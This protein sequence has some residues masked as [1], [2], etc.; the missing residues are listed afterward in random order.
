MKKELKRKAIIGG[1]LSL[2]ALLFACGGGGGGGDTT[3]GVTPYA[4]VSG[5]VSASSN[6]AAGVVSAAGI[7]VNGVDVAYI[8][9]MGIE[10]G[11]L[12]Y[13]ADD[14]DS[15]GNFDLNLKTGLDYAFILFDSS[16][17]PVFFVNGTTGNAISVNSSGSVTITLVDT[18]GDGTPDAAQVAQTQ[19]SVS[20][21]SN[22]DLEDDPNDPDYYPESIEG[23]DYGGSPNPD[24][25]EDGDGYFDGVENN[26]DDNY[27]DGKE[28]SNNNG[29]PDVYE[30]EDSDGLPN[31]LDD[32]DGD[33]YYDHIDED[34]SDYYRYEMKGNVSNI[35]TTN[36]TFDFTYNNTTYTVSVTPQ[37]VCEIYDAYYT[38][39]ECINRIKDNDYIELKTSDD[40]NATTNITA[41]KFELENYDDDDNYTYNTR[42]EVY[43]TVTEID[44]GTQSFQFYYNNRYYTVTVDNNTKCEYNDMYYYGADCLMYLS[45]GNYIELKTYDNIFEHT[46]ITAVEIEKKK[47]EIY[48][49][50]SAYDDTNNTIT[51]RWN[52]TD[53]TGLITETT[54]CEINDRYYYGADCFTAMTTGAYYE[55]KTYDNIYD[56]N[57]DTITIYEL[58]LED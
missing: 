53:Y 16:R 14:I 9:A 32:S 36:Y 25:D 44:T 2:S 35:D 52:N 11:K 46:E 50:I 33:G 15:N 27:V 6:T 58:E 1:S 17:N 57:T 30:D 55:I 37:T 13:T 28:D 18:N 45:P 7:N 56:G 29:I 47:F 42:Y 24:Y 3:T 4:T 41:V 23:I 22:P 21:V 8:A 26:D 38:G 54:K 20:V 51:F 48:G 31:Y 34:D 5:T 39:Y 19:G 49:M 12:V 40:I 43:G 10:N